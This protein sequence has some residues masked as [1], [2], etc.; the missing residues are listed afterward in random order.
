[1]H[2]K[3]T[4]R[5]TT[6]VL[7][8]VRQ[9]L[10]RAIL[11]VVCVVLT[12]GAAI[13]A[14]CQQ[15]NFGN[16][17]EHFKQEATGL[18]ISQQTIA[19]GLNGIAYDPA[20]IARDHSQSVF[21]QSFE[22]FSGRMVSP[23]RLRK[24][25]NMLKRYGS[26]LERI[27]DR[28]GVPAEVL[29]AIWGLESDYG[30]NQG[31]YSTVRSLATLAYD[32]RRSEKFHAELLDALRLIERGDLTSHEMIGAWAGEIG[33]TQFLPSTYL[34]FA[35]DFEGLGHRDLI[36]SAL[37]ALASTANYL[38]NYGWLSGKPWTEGAVNFGALQKWN[39]SEVYAKTVAYFATRLAKEP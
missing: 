13:A 38:K 28:C 26:I 20:I 29:V 35:V 25:A 31:K 24:G 33:Q 39:E 36:H 17:L 22:Q 27:E 34:R 6:G 23:D 32:C 7:M 5:S 11:C 8:L 14:A 15:D 21:Q 4:T 19:S 37:N 9:A 30:V 16:W 3:L 2:R 12:I 18:G 10:A 1:M